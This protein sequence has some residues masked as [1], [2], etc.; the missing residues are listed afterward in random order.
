MQLPT[1]QPCVLILENSSEGGKYGASA[2][3]EQWVQ[4]IQSVTQQILSA[5]CIPGLAPREES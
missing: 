3:G 5:Y 1:W 4:F 2:T